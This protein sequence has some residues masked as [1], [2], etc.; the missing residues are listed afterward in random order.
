MKTNNTYQNVCIDVTNRTA[1]F[2]NLLLCK[3]SLHSKKQGVSLSYI[4]NSNKVFLG[5]D[6]PIFPFREIKK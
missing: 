4:P 5:F 2:I 1:E 3:M 6:K